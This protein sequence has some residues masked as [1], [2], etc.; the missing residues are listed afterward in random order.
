MSELKFK[1]IGIILKKVID[2][3]IDTDQGL[4]DAIGQE[5]VKKIKLRTKLGQGVREFGGNP[6][7]FEPLMS[8]KNNMTGKPSTVEARKRMTDLSPETS[9]GKSNLTMTGQMLNSITYTAKDKMVS[10]R[11]DNDFAKKKATWAEDG[12]PDRAPRKFFNLS[13][14]EING[15]QKIAID[16]LK[17]LIKKII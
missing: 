5:A 8:A 15:M 10:I 1:A 14:S 11:F 13:S 17:R 2:K 7:K 6:F 9:P 3:I 12:S 4:H 16:Y